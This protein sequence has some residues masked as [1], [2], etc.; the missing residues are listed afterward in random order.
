MKVTVYNFFRLGNRVEY[1]NNGV[2]CEISADVF[3]C[4]L[5]QYRMMNYEV[6]EN[7]LYVTV[8]KVVVSPETFLKKFAKNA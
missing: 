8:V 7:D 3:A 6:T 2:T 4:M 5:T 1:I